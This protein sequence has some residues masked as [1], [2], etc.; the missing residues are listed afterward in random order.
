MSIKKQFFVN[1]QEFYTNDTITLSDL[2]FFF[3]YRKSL[4]VLEYNNSICDRTEWN[5]IYI[6]NKDKIEIVTIVGGG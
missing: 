1:G 2:I 4:F 5:K 6:T 3:N